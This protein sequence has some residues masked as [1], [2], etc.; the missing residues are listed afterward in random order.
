MRRHFLFV[1]CLAL[2]SSCSAS[3]QSNL[4]PKQFN[5]WKRAACS[6]NPSQFAFGTEAGLKWFGSCQFSS[7]SDTVVISA[8]KYLDPSSAFEVYTGLLRPGMVPTNLGQVSAFDKDGVIIQ[9]GA[10]VLS[11]SANISKS[12]LDA[13]VKSVEAVGEVGPLPPIRTYLPLAGRAIGSERYALGPEAMRS[14]MTEL[15]QTNL[16]ALV[17]LAGFSDGAEAMLA[18][19]SSREKDGAVLLLIEYPTPQLAEQHIHHLDEALPPNARQLGLN[20]I[21]KGSLLSM[22]L[23]ATSLEFAHNLRAAINYENQVTWN[24]PSQ[25]ATDPSL[26]SMMVKIFIGTGFFMIAAIV[27]GIAFGGVRI[28]TKIFLPGKVFDRH[29]KLEI[30]QLGLNG[31]RIEPT[32]F[33]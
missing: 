12:D 17:N 25:T 18:R 29:S 30:L 9:E 32:D 6:S 26:P 28:L 20:V 13:L 4:L 23:S 16:L 24:E 3:A 21:R 10:V 11:S 2:V 31:K 14:A 1:C 27:L 22:V 33:Y 5:A 15:G 7:G 8:G 19:Y